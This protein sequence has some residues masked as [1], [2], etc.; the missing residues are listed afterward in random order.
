MMVPLKVSRSTIRGA[1]AGVG[2]RFKVDLGA[3]DPTQAYTLG[4]PDTRTTLEVFLHQ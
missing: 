1:E 3:P 2:E 4:S